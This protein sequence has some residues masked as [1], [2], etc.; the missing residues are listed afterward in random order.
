MEKSNFRDGKVQF[1]GWK[2]PISGMEK[3][4]FRG[5]EITFLMRLIRIISS[6]GNIEYVRD[7][8]EKNRMKERKSEIELEKR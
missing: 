7:L 5:L 4:N 1:Q 6:F 3:S 2:S 8:N